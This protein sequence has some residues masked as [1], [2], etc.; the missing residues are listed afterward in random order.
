MSKDILIDRQISVCLRNIE[1]ACCSFL[2]GLLV[3]GIQLI[4]SLYAALESVQVQ[5][6]PACC[7]IILNNNNQDIY[8]ETNPTN[9]HQ[10]F[11]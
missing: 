2:L 3:G 10:Q 6:L 5:N 4:T 8:R 9:P 1:A 11:Y 7:V